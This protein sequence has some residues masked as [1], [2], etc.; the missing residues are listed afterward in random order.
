MKSVL[1]VVGPTATG[2][3]DL[4]VYLSQV[5]GGEVVN[6]DSRQVYR[7]M[8]IGTAKPRQEQM[9]L[10]RH[11]LIDIVE[12]DE[13]FSLATYQDL[14]YEAIRDI[15]KR[16]KVPILTGGTGLYVWS[17]IEGWRI[18]QVRSEKGLRDSLEEK[19]RTGPPDI[20]YNE[21]LKVDPDSAHAIA[22]SNTRR[23]IR[24]LEV[25]YV[26]GTPLSVLK[27][28]APPD[29]ETA[30]VGLTMNREELYRRI[31]QRVDR[32]IAS[33]LVEET[34]SLV[35]K[36]YSPVLPSMSGIGYRE[37]VNV[38]KGEIEL[39]AAV[40]KIKNATHNFARHQY[41]WFHLADS[42]IRWFDVGTTERVEILEHVRGCLASSD[43][44]MSFPG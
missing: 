5:L 44:D 24:A 20:L 39:E 34:K 36:G 17:I 23:I 31:D 8:E 12:P 29:F 37:I 16:G 6:A 32:M 1:A 43:R 27:T 11:H 28:K 35:E 13:E 18:P 15:R 7:H 30:I 4:A 2:K 33:G 42:R 41:A 19:A 10:V 9:K 21:L 38:L 26:T 22:P 3:S 25:F 40:A 14:A